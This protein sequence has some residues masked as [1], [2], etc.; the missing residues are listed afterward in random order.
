M[1]RQR[2]QVSTSERELI[3]HHLHSGKS[4]RQIGK[5]VNRSHTTVQGI[6]NRFLYQHRIKN[7]VRKSPKKIFNNYDERWILRKVAQDPKISA[8]R[9]AKLV[10]KYLHKKVN[11]QTIRNLLNRH[12]IHSRV[13]RKKPWVSKVNRTKRLIFA[14]EYRDKDF[15]FWKN[16]LFTDESKFNLFGSDGQHRVWRKPNE[17]LKQHLRATV[18]HGGGSVMVWGCMTAKGPGFLHF[19]DGI[20]DQNMYLEILKG[21]VKQSAQKLEIEETFY[22]YQDNDPK[23]KAQKVRSWLLYN[24]PKVIETPPQSPDLNVIEN[25]WSQLKVAIRNHTISNKEQLKTVLMEEWAKI[26]PEYCE[27]LVQSM[28]NRLKEVIRNKGFPTKY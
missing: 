17:A 1:G 24:C 11:P 22:F 28:P 25:L 21:N 3:I 15:S 13:A 5:I 19:I 23:H 6:V 8:P 12:K 16:V 9:L 26:T 2:G 14:E 4:Y 18:K 27:K 20:M 7:K 10:E